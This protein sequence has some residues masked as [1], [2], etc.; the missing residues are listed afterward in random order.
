M[1]HAHRRA[2]RSPPRQKQQDR[3]DDLTSPERLLEA[4][5]PD[6]PPCEPMTRRMIQGPG[7]PT[8]KEFASRGA[9]PSKRTSRRRGKPQVL[10]PSPHSLPGRAAVISSNI[11]SKSIDWSARHSHTKAPMLGFCC[12]S[13]RH[14]RHAVR[15]RRPLPGRHAGR[16]ARQGRAQQPRALTR[17][18]LPSRP[19]AHLCS[20]SR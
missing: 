5:P 11:S 3:P 20:R 1:S 14:R 15:A 6:R 7:V 17:I 13:D 4:M 9:C 16:A 18:L 8:L 19:A 10:M 2:A 12:S